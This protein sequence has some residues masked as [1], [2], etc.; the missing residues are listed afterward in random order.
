VDQLNQHHDHQQRR[1]QHQEIADWLTKID[2][3]AQHN[4][5]L[6]RR[7]AGT[8]QHILE[9]DLFQ[10]WLS[11]SK[12][13]LFYSGIP[14]AGKTM[15]ACIV[16]ENLLKRFRFQEDVGIAYVY[17]NYGQHRTQKPDDVLLSILK[18]LLQQSRHIPEL[19][20]QFHDRH[21]A[22]RLRPSCDEI[23]EVLYSTIQLYSR[24]F[25]I[26]DALDEC[27]SSDEGRWSVLSEIHNLKSQT[28]A[29]IFAT[30]RPFPE[31][32]ALF[33]DELREEISATDKDVTKYVDGRMPNLLRRR[34]IKY[35]D[36]QQEIRS[37]IVD[38]TDGM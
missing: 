1:Q 30:S 26:V 8:G 3:S 38:A 18:Q 33:G 25:I 36:L 32:V 22:T 24:T 34:I 14:G 13:T 5:F 17:C 6:S 35:P 7:Q 31:I 10:T 15:V 29:N 19:I 37:T 28:S 23:R 9:S 2:Y 16:T 27:H 21:Q 20:K 4:D 11:S 12:K